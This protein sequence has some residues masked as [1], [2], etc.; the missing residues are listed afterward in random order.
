LR[1]LVP[2]VIVV[3]VVVVVVLIILVILVLV[4]LIVLVLLILL[5]VLIVLVVATI[6]ITVAIIL[7]HNASGEQNQREQR[8]LHLEIFFGFYIFLVKRVFA[9]E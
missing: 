3:L 1:I 6:A 4:V 9:C 2:A 7:G 8:G 5:V